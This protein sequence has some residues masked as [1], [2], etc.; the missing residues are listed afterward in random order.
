MF[1]TCDM[2]FH[3]AKGLAKS[4]RRW[5]FCCPAMNIPLVKVSN[6]MERYTSQVRVFLFENTQA[7]RAD[8]SL[9]LPAPSEV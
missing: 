7:K 8:A 5:S 9:N 1:L 3:F 2:H 6:K 4:L